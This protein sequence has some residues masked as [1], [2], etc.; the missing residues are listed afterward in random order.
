[1]ER[2]LSKKFAKVT[3]EKIT[4]VNWRSSSSAKAISWLINLCRTGHTTYPTT[5]LS[6]PTTTIMARRT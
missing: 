5:G 1:M 6:S 4:D 3:Q 2:L